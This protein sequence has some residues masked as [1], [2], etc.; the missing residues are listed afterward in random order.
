MHRVAEECG[1]PI[2]FGVV[3]DPGPGGLR[4][5]VVHRIVSIRAEMADV[6]AGVGV[7]DEYVTVAVAVGHIQAVSR[8]VDHHVGRLEQQ[9]RAANN[10]MHVVAVRSLGSSPDP[11][12]EIAVHVE[13]QDQAVAAC[14]VRRPRHIGFAGNTR[15]SRDPYVV[16]LV[17]I[18]SVLT[19]WPD[20]ACLLLTLTA[21]ETR[22]RWTTPGT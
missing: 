15:I 5:R 11:H 10:A 4:A 22:I 8:G 9:R 18:N 12:L 20:A 1:F 17:D 2:A 7:D 19:L 13:L 14:L 16:L 6:F 21:D 3:G